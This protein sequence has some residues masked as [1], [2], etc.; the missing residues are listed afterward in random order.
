MLNLKKFGAGFGS[1]AA[2]A[3]STKVVVRVEPGVLLERQLPW[4]VGRSDQ[5]VDPDLLDQSPRLGERLRVEL[6][7]SVASQPK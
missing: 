1:G 5:D 6:P 2:P 3:P 4:R 7:P